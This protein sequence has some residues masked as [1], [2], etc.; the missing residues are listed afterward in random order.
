MEKFVK[1]WFK[2]LSIGTSF[3]MVWMLCFTLVALALPSSV[4]DFIGI[5]TDTTI[6]LVWD[7]SSANSTLIRH[8]TATYPA[9]I[10]DGTV[11]YNGT[12]NFVTVTGLTAG[13]AY[14]F[15]AWNW[16]DTGYSATASN[17]VVNTLPSVADNTTIPFDKPT[18]PAEV[19]QDPDI[20]GWSIDPID[21]ILDYFADEAVAH[22]GLGMPVE[23]VVMFMAGVGVTFVSLG[24]Y[25][26]W[27]SFFSS[28]FIAL[29][30]SS[31]L[32]S[33]EVMQWI[34]VLFLLLVGAGV[35]A[36]EKS[37]Q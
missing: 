24:T 31:L 9:T 25:V 22:G 5:A 30:L 28:W 7:A 14:Y 15:S 26:K 12:A 19:S 29:I 6:S 18:L 17:L 21:K 34:V 33:I 1:R 36:V 20:S 32:C 11:S 16:D 13:T 23:N 3:A 2:R 37:A 35:W 8:S 27:R 10:A 4:T